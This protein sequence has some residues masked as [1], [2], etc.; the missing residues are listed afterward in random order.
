MEN[1][2]L[3]TQIIAGVLFV[4]LLI[5]GYFLISANKELKESHASQDL[6]VSRDRIQK[7]CNG[8]QGAKAPA[9]VKD[10]NELADTLTQYS[11]SITNPSGTTTVETGVKP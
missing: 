2:L 7:D 6:T 5:C 3:V 11:K 4:L 9:C 10:L 8:P 1:K